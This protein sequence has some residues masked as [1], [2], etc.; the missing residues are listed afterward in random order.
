MIPKTPDAERVSFVFYSRERMTA[1]DDMECEDCR[2]DFMRYAA[3]N[4]KEYGNGHKT[5]NGVWSGM[6]KSPEWM[7]YK[8]EHGLER[9]SNTNY[10]GTEN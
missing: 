7:T 10:R 4:H 9:C 5:W 3:D 1:L 6:W 2:R 8:A